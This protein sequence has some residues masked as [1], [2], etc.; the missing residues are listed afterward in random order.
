MLLGCIADD[1]TGAS[2]LANTLARAG[3]RT[4]QF[5]GV[6][7]AGAAQE[8]EAGVVALKS[9]STPAKE[10][11]DASLGALEWLKTQ[12]CEQYLF[13][14]CST[15][16]STKE[17]NIGPVAKALAEKLGAKAVIFCPAFPGA[18]RTV[19][20]GHLFVFDKLLSETGMAFHPLN[21]MTDSDLRRWL[22]AQSGD[23]PV[24][25][26]SFAT[27]QAGV[28]AIR[29]QLQEVSATGRLRS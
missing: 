21:P 7:D 24:T 4:M 10:A 1:F 19:Y 26:L 25:H 29:K 13:K 2:D 23:V 12:G 5:I 6:P 11:V 8:C 15:F 14:Y 17:G 3:L 20:Q 16:N 18:G 27:I 9:R 22:Q 28:A